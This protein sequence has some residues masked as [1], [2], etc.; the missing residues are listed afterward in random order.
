MTI[1]PLFLLACLAQA[2]CDN[3]QTGLVPLND[4]GSGTYL[5]VF[6]GGLYPGGSNTPPAAHAVE[7]MARAAALQ[8]LDVLGQPAL[9]GWIGMVSIGM[10]TTTQSSPSPLRMLSSSSIW[11]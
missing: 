8:S 6:Q 2:D 5:G 7:G 3:T 9:H 11:R 1:A 4:L 10:S